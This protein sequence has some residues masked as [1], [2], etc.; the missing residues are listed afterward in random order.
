MTLPPAFSNVLANGVGQFLE[1]RTTGQ[2]LLRLGKDDDLLFVATGSV[3]FGDARH[4]AQLRF[5]H[6]IV[7]E[8]KFHQL[9]GAALRLVR[10]LVAGCIVHHV[11]VN[12]AEASRDRRKFGR[13][14][15]GQVVDRVLQALAHELAGAI[16]VRSFLK[17][18]RNLRQPELGKRPKLGHS[19]NAEHLD[20]Q[21]IGDQFLDFLRRETFDLGVDLDLDVRDVGN[22]I[23]GKT[24]SRPKT[25]N[26]EARSGE[27][28]KDS[29]AQRK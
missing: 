3:D 24:G 18:Q 5:D 8:L 20:F 27:Q 17:D 9:L 19:R 2:E 1:R 26:H 15:L 16:D 22:G 4:A 25:G 21:R 7:D 12:F 29:L 11:V 23:D 13:D 28:D 6:E 10:A 14:V